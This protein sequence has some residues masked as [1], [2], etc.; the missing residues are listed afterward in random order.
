MTPLIQITNCRD[1]YGLLTKPVWSRW[2]D[3]G[4]VLFLRLYAPRR[5]NTQKRTKLI[6]SHLSRTSLANKGLLYGFGKFFLGR[7]GG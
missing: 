5:V 3:I 2:L 6:S 7:K 1:T 4:Q